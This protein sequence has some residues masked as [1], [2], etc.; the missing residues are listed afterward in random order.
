M[1]K[2]FKD[3]AES[4]DKK[5]DKL[6][7]EALEGFKKARKSGNRAEAEKFQTVLD[8]I[9]GRE[10]EAKAGREL[11]KPKSDK[12]IKVKTPAERIDTKTETGRV[13]SV[14]EKIDTKSPVKTVEGTTQKLKSKTPQ[15]TKTGEEFKKSIAEKLQKKATEKAPKPTVQRLPGQKAILGSKQRSTTAKTIASKLGE[16]AQESR[17]ARTAAVETAET[18]G[19]KLAKKGTKK[20]AST[21]GKKLLS[22]IPFVGGLAAALAT[23]D[24]EA[25]IPDEIRSTPTGPR[26][27]TLEAALESGARLTPAQLADLRRQQNEQTIE[28]RKLMKENKD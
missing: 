12:K 16:G 17:L 13:K 18:V 24:A 10:Q 27:G 2:F 28:A 8:K 9:R 3:D 25:A 4:I 22:A 1:A 6:K 15:T 7:K 11:L 14:T 20:A 19:S 21:V 26:A 23:G 5:I